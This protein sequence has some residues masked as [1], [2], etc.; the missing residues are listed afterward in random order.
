MLGMPSSVLWGVAGL[1]LIALEALVIPGSYTIW[2]GLAAILTGIVLSLIA[3]PSPWDWLLFGVAALAFAALGWRVYRGRAREE[4]DVPTLNDPAA[5][6]VGK[7]FDLDGAI[8]EGVGRIRWHDTVWRVTGP[9]LP[10]GAR[11]KVVA[12][13]GATLVVEAA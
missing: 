2:I 5:A 4:A 10:A 3:V 1:L 13:D 12:L 11:V 8:V 7:S 6:L 9:S